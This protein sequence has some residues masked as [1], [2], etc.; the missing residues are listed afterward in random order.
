MKKYFWYTELSIMTDPAL[1]MIA[2]FKNTL[3]EIRT[4]FFLS[5]SKCEASNKSNRQR[6][7][8]QTTQAFVLVLVVSLL[9][10]VFSVTVLL[11]K[12]ERQSLAAAL[13]N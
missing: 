8:K 9:Q 7:L 11:T 3:D 6:T 1:T 12:I 13:N 4:L 10:S 5:C 2:I